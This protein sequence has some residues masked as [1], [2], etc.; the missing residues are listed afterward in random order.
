MKLSLVLIDSP[1]FAFI[2]L[3][4]HSTVAENMEMITSPHHRG[5]THGTHLGLRDYGHIEWHK[6]MGRYRSSIE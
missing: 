6:L 5:T 4:A 1:Y 3:T 2:T